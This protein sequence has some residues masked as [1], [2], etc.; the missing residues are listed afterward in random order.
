M[1]AFAEYYENANDEDEEGEY[2]EFIE[3][4]NV[5][6]PYISVYVENLSE[7]FIINLKKS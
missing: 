1:D 7:N 2:D 3:E 5:T 4:F 6:F